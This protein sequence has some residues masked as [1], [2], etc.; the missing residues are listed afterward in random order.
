[1]LFY[2]QITT[3]DSKKTTGRFKSITGGICDNVQKYKLQ[4]Q[5]LERFPEA[6]AGGTDG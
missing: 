2:G 1:L 6:G 5:P 4:E 3:S